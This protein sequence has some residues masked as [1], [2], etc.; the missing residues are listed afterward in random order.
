MRPRTTIE[1]RTNQNDAEA[2]ASRDLSHMFLPAI[3]QETTTQRYIEC[4]KVSMR[5]LLHLG[6]G[7]ECHRF[8]ESLAQSPGMKAFP[9]DE[10]STP[11]T[12]H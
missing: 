9:N 7:L 8:P 12:Y 10:R 3:L 5:E 4:L 2:D 6:G 1:L 11:I